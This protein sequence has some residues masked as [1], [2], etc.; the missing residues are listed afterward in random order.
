[1]AKLLSRT[2]SNIQFLGRSKVEGG[3]VHEDGNDPEG[4]IG[5]EDGNG[6][7]VGTG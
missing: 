6:H 7:E 3:G 2:C 1:M 5:S 4:G